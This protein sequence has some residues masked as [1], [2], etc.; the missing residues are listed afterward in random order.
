[1]A[2]RHHKRPVK[3][4]DGKYTIKGKK[5]DEVIGTRAKVWHG[6]AYKTSG[7]LK[8]ED[9]TQN[10]GGLIVSKRKQATAKRNKRLSKW[11]KDHGLRTQKGKFGLFAK[12]GKRFTGKSTRRRR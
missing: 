6:T 3:G 2:P 10:K 4:P 8:R 1:M 5:Y 9:L 7:G 12:D 11:M